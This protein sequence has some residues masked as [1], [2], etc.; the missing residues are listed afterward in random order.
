MFGFTTLKRA[1]CGAAPRADNVSK[2]MDIYD[3]Y[4]AALRADDKYEQDRTDPNAS[5][6]GL[7]DIKILVAEQVA[8]RARQ[9]GGIRVAGADCKAFDQLTN[10]MADFEESKGMVFPTTTREAV[11]QLVEQA[12]YVPAPYLQSGR[13]KKEG[14]GGGAPT[15]GKR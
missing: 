4:A 8:H 10:E 12:G 1:F 7:S 15:F 2:R 9:F 14:S 11:A 13:I 3:F 5:V 6:F